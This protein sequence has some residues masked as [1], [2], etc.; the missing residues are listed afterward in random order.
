MPFQERNVIFASGALGKVGGS[1]HTPIL[2]HNRLMSNRDHPLPPSRPTANPLLS[3]IRDGAD[4]PS[5]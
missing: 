5:G 1:S 4:T 3:N 2:D